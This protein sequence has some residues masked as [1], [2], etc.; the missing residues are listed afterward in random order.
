MAHG[1]LQSPPKRSV[2]SSFDQRTNVDAD[3]LTHGLDE[4]ESTRRGTV[5]SAVQRTA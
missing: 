4:F 5:E 1:P 2:P 3:G